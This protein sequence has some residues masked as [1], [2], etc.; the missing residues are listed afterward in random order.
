MQS[1]PGCLSK[2]DPFE[3]NRY[4]VEGIVAPSSAPPAIDVVGS[5]RN[6]IRS[7]PLIRSV[8]T[9]FGPASPR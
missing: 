6:Q 7:H 8:S 2:N 4:T 5:P 9:F 3:I 1:R